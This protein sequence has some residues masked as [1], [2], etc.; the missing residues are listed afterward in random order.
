MDNY[1]EIFN[2]K[3]RNNEVVRFERIVG[4]DGQAELRE[5]TEENGN[6]DAEVA[7]ESY[8]DEPF[9]LQDEEL[10]DKYLQFK[11]ERDLLLH[12]PEYHRKI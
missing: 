2:E 10:E 4:D 1:N 9:R 8:Y 12:P 11:E 5:I 3:C 6:L 7:H